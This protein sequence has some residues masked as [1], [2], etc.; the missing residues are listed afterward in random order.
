MPQHHV[1]T[2]SDVFRKTISALLFFLFAAVCLVSLALAALSG[3]AT[4][5]L[6]LGLLS[7]AF[8]FILVLLL[9]KCWDQIPLWSLLFL[10]LGIKLAFVLCFSVPPEGDYHTFLI[11]AS[12]MSQGILPGTRSYLALFPH[13]LGYSG[14]LSIFLR[15]FGEAPLVATILN[16]VLSC[17]SMLF[18]HAICDQLI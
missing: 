16:V 1:H 15:I 9:R 2:R 13:I 11:T 6:L 17:V 5:R 7:A 4:S 3:G 18:L 14:F 8:I 12:D 10:C